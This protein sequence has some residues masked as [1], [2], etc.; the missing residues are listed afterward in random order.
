VTRPDHEPTAHVLGPDG[1]TPVRFSR[2]ENGVSVN[3]D[4]ITLKS[5]AVLDFGNGWTL[6]TVEKPPGLTFN[7]EDE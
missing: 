1:V 6:K 5:G 3:L 2:W 4:E 7:V